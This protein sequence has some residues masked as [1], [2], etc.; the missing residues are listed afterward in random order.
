M[1]PCFSLLLSLSVMRYRF[2]CVV[3]NNR[4][5]F[6][7]KAEWYSIIK[8][9]KMCRWRAVLRSDTHSL[10]SWC[11]GWHSTPHPSFSFSSEA[12]RKPL[13]SQRVLPDTL[14]SALLRHSQDY[15]WLFKYQFPDQRNS[16]KNCKQNGISLFHYI[17]VQARHKFFKE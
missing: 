2:I 6:F 4:V 14:L 15:L 17:N 13:L 16:H 1:I 12:T 9:L 7:F 5:S 10:V 11:D 8:F 3:A